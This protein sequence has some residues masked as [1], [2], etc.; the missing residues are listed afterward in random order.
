MLIWQ[1]RVRE[2][3]Q[4]TYAANFFTGLMDL[5]TFFFLVMIMYSDLANNC[6]AN[7]IIFWGKNTTL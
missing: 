4:W 7:L 5:F 3:E 1:G 2:S 6:V